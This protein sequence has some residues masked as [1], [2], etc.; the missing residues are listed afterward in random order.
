MIT[1]AHVKPWSKLDTPTKVVADTATYSYD[2]FDPD[3]DTRTAKIYVARF[4]RPTEKG[5]KLACRPEAK[6]VVCLQTPPEIDPRPTL[7]RL[8]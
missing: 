4:D 5:Q 2:L 7:A 3:N 1:A 6:R 8:K